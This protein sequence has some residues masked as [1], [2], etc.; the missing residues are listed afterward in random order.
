MQIDSDSATAHRR[1]L[2]NRLQVPHIRPER[3]KIAPNA[4]FAQL[5]AHRTQPTPMTYPVRDAWIAADTWTLIDRRNATLRQHAPQLELRAI[6]KAI[7][8]KVKRDRATRLQWT[9]EE[10]QAHLDDN[11]AAEAWR[12]VKVWYRHNEQV[13]PPTPANLTAI[14]REYRA[15]YTKQEPPGAPIRGMVTYAIPDGIP[16]EDEIATAVRMLRS[17]QAAGASGMSTEDIKRW[18]TERADNPKPWRL[19]IR[20]VQQAFE[21]GV[22]PTK[23][24]ANTLVLIPKP[25]PEQVRGIG[26][27]EPIW[28]LIS[29]IVNRRLMQHISFHEDLHGFLPARGTGTACLEAK[30]EAQLA[31]RS[32]RPLHHIFLDFSKAY[33]S[34]NRERT[35]T[36][37]QDYGVGPN[38][39]RIIATFWERHMVMP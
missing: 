31:F 9:G 37:L 10:I 8:K 6:R 5:L 17:G 7:R 36:I 13:V 21:T 35:I 1:Y 34:L 27:L 23:A 3:D 18:H 29:A 11:N 26:L 28:K 30:L 20:L 39:I 32:G 24:C 33:D 14:E 16:D 25:E 15:L 22:V 2:H 12:L 19:T 4:M 38:V